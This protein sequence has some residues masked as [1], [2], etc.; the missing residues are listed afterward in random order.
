MPYAISV[1]RNV[2][3][4]QLVKTAGELSVN[5]VARLRCVIA[6]RTEDPYLP[7]GWCKS[8]IWL[9]TIL[10]HDMLKGLYKSLVMIAHRLD[11]FTDL[12]HVYDDPLELE[13]RDLEQIAKRCSD[14]PAAVRSG[15]LG[16][17]WSVLCKILSGTTDH[18]TATPF[19]VFHCNVFIVGFLMH[20]RHNTF[21]HTL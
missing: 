9:S 8:L 12:P 1:V 16:S 4:I 18:G 13:E 3:D 21:I 20:L 14:R 11:A 15:D 6:E 17:N 19:A 10:V 5:H 2:P 7:V